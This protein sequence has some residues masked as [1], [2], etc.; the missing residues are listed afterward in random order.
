MK[1]MQK[2]LTLLIIA[3]VVAFLSLQRPGSDSEDVLFSDLGQE[4]YPD[5]KDPLEVTSLE[6]FEYN[7]ELAALTPFKV[8]LKDGQWTIPS[9]NDYPVDAKEKMEKL[10]SSLIGIKKDEVRSDKPADQKDLELIDPN[11]TQVQALAGR[12][13][14]ITLKN[15]QGRILADYILGAELDER[16]E[17]RFIR[18]PG[19]HKS[20]AAKI[21]LDL[22]TNFADWI[23][24]SLLD[25]SS[26]NARK[27]ILSDYKVDQGRLIPG[28]SY[29]LDKQD[30][31]WTTNNTPEGKELDQ[32][33]IN[34]ILSELSSLKI[35]GVRPKPAA[36]AATLSLNKGLS[37]GEEEIASLADK[38]FYVTNNGQL[39]SNEGEATFTLESGVSYAIRF[40]N[41]FFASGLEVSAGTSSNTKTTDEKKNS[42]ASRYLFIMA[43]VD[44]TFLGPAPKRLSEVSEIADDADEASKKA[45]DEK[46]AAY[47][48]AEQ[49]YKTWQDKK[50]AAEEA[51]AKL[52]KRFAKWY[53]VINGSSYDAIRVSFEKL[54]KDKKKEEKPSSPIQ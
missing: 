51:V 15:A 37:M 24:T 14:R 26:S 13:T 35:V 49:A 2:T 20:Y 39:F 3:V 29:Q 17:Y 50:K 36:L 18:Q 8:L 53:Y 40:G 46:V 28:K 42:T 47:E 41:S 34:P 23:N 31:D 16:S 32:S 44:S 48:K 4:F 6:V 19:S 12:G 45:H 5:F 1:E 9:H 21:D 30:S 43:Q 52:N 11:D 27:F 22:S 25:F 33:K 10:A 7:S 54:L 38:G